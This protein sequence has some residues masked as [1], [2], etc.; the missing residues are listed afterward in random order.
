MHN[1]ILSFAEN[2]TKEEEALSAAAFADGVTDPSQAIVSFVLY[3]L[4]ESDARAESDYWAVRMEY[5]ELLLKLWGAQAVD[6]NKHTMAAV[7]A[8]STADLMSKAQY[9]QLQAR[10]ARFEVCNP[11]PVS[12]M[13]MHACLT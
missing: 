10:V 9:Q 8:A 13:E 5:V 6:R 1:P 3:V 2:C 12:L 4:P 7:S 11:P